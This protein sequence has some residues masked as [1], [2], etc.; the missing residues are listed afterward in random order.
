MES[1]GFF[2]QS[3]PNYDRNI[4]LGMTGAAAAFTFLAVSMGMRFGLHNTVG[5]SLLAGVVGTLPTTVSGVIAAKLFEAK[6]DSLKLDFSPK[7]LA[8]NRAFLDRFF[9]KRDALIRHATQEAQQEASWSKK[10]ELLSNCLKRL[11]RPENVEPFGRDGSSDD[12]HAQL[13]NRHKALAQQKP[14]DSI[15]NALDA[16]E[17]E[18]D[19]KRKVA[20]LIGCMEGL[21]EQTPTHETV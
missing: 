3:N 13:F 15:T 12:D 14:F 9:G 19:D 8:R 5:V 16:S 6:E 18:S 21:I 10:V 7:K 17:K 2:S 20:I 11:D 4:A 1:V